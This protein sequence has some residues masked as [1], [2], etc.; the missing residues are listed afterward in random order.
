MNMKWELVEM[1]KAFAYAKSRDIAENYNS[2][3]YNVPEEASRFDFKIV[4]F[5]DKTAILV[6]RT[7]FYIGKS[8]AKETQEYYITQICSSSGWLYSRR[9]D[10]LPQ[11]QREKSPDERIMKV[12]ATLE[13]VE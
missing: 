7:K 12:S 9:Y 2:Y 3:V 8:V 6:T 5:S 11:A 10:T 1:L 13:E 4:W